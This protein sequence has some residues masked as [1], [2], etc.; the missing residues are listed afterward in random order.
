[1]RANGIHDIIVMLNDIDYNK[2]KVQIHDCGLIYTVFKLYESIILFH[3]FF[4]DLWFK[5]C[6]PFLVSHT[7]SM[8]HDS[9]LSIFS[10]KS[11]YCKFHLF[12]AAEE[13]EEVK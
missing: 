10:Y 2:L 11:L 8:Y 4:V 12:I 7:L 9:S 5:P 3:L 6:L 1:M 13:D